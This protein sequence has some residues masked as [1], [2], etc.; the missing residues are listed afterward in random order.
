MRET[1]LEALRR[2]SGEEQI[3]LEFPE[4]EAYG[5]YSTNLALILAKKTGKNP[6]EVAEE[7][8][9]GLKKDSQLGEFVSKIEVAGPGF[10]NFFLSESALINEI[11][12]IEKEKEAYGS[13]NLGE[14]GTVVIDYSSPN[15]AKRFGIG[16]LRSTVIGQAL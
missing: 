5:D 16:H 14:G 2:V 11:S 15:I 4:P 1:I 7:I 3:E 13:S 6:K 12:E 9:S 8:T 10:I